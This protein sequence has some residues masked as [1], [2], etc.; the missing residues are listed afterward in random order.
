LYPATKLDQGIPS[1]P[2]RSGKLGCMSDGNVLELVMIDF[3]MKAVHG[4]SANLQALS[5]GRIGHLT[6]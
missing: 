6:K 5:D 2:N 3:G 4:F 1:E